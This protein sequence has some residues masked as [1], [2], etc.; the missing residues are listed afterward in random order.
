MKRNPR[1]LVSGFGPFLDEKVNPT[2][3]IAKYVN[4]ASSG[5]S[6]GRPAWRS[7]DVRGL[8]LPVEFDDAFRRLE[9][10]RLLFQ[11]DVILSFGLAAGRASIDVEQ[12]AINLR[13]T[14]AGGEAIDRQAPLALR[15]TLP[16]AEILRALAAAGLPAGRSFSAGTYV[17]NDLFFQMQNRL[18]WTRVQSGFIHVPRLDLSDWPLSRFERAVD[19]I[20]GT[21]A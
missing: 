19:A 14:D 6:A 20:L 5:G 11:P 15:T 17:C 4:Q 1:V 8:V 18:R 16:S 2:Q 12:V 21:F 3:M 10:E 9:R 7:L 13:G